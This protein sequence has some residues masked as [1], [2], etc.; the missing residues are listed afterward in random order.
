[1]KDKK[2]YIVVKNIEGLNVGDEI[3]TLGNIYFCF[4]KYI[5]FMAKDVE[6]N[7]EYFLLKKGKVIKTYTEQ[8]MENCFQSARLMTRCESAVCRAYKDFDEYL[9]LITE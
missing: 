9:K 3:S 6:N 2:T 7:S 1:M 4:S 8:D 5:G